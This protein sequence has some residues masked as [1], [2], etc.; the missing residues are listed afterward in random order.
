G[1]QLA[2][3]NGGHTPD[4]PLIRMLTPVPGNVLSLMYNA[5]DL[6]V[7][8]SRSE[9]WCNAITEALACGTPVVATAVGGN[10]EQFALPDLGILVPDGDAGALR[11]A[12]VDAL[13]RTWNRDAITRAGAARTWNETSL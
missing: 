1:Q 10:P 9:G 11:Q 4:D 3:A 5:A 8:A 6:L 2:E 7:N 12:I 13:T